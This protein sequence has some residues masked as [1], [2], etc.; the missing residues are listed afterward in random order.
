MVSNGNGKGFVF[1]MASPPTNAVNTRPA[2]ALAID[3][4]PPSDARPRLG[5]RGHS[6]DG[7]SVPCCN[8]PILHRPEIPYPARVNDKRWGRVHGRAV[9][10]LQELGGRKRRARVRK[11]HSDLD[12]GKSLV[13]R[14]VLAPRH[15]HCSKKA[16]TFVSAAGKASQPRPAK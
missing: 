2:T 11:C 4:I 13:G 3:H 1:R 8:L 15:R 9:R 10:L 5:R 14:T 12:D 16:P 7:Q 6:E